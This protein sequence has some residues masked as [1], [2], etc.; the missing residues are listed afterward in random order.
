MSV[1]CPGDE[2]QAMKG[3]HFQLLVSPLQKERQKVV[4]GVNKSVDIPD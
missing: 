4:Q 3:L 1:L 2:K